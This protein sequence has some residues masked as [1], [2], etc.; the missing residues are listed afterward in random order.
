MS[1]EFNAR[2]LR[3]TV[4]QWAPGIRPTWTV[5]QIRAALRAH[6][7][8]D[9]SQSALL[10]DAMMQDDALPGELEKRVNAV[11]QS[12]CDLRPVSKHDADGKDVPVEASKQLTEQLFGEDWYH[13]FPEDELS[14]LLTWFRMLRVA[15]GTL[16]WTRGPNKW[17]PRLRVLHPQFLM[18]QP[19]DGVW[20]YQSREGRQVVTPGDGQWILLTDGQRGYARSSI[21]ALAVSWIIKQL[22]LRDWNR[23]NERHGLPI[24]K[25]FA[26]MVADEGDR[27][28]FFEDVKALN[29]ETTMLLPTHM[30]ADSA[31]AKYDLELLEAKDTAWETFPKLVDRQDRKFQVHFCGGNLGSEVSDKGSRAAADTHKGV[32]RDLATGDEKRFSTQLRDQGFKPIVAFNAGPNRVDDTPWPHWTTE[33]SEDTKGKAEGQKAFGDALTAFKTAGYKVTNIDELSEQFGVELEE[34]EPP[35]PPPGTPPPG[36][37]P[38]GGAGGK[39]PPPPPAGKAKLAR[40]DDTD[41]GFENGADYVDRLVES[42]TRRA[43]DALAVD[44][45]AILR[46]VQAAETPAMLRA[47]LAALYSGMDQ[48]ELGRVLERARLMAELAGK[49][50]VI[51]D[52]LDA[53]E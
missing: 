40:G 31:D 30:I 20:Y 15:V 24:V 48:T 7:E 12:D 39:Q 26:P 43:A 22:A 32:L 8:G 41:P 53:A 47:G 23:Y 16:D 10:A 49:Y 5:S 36:M 19:F 52:V 50:S 44:I 3:L 13:W 11:I 29:T 18:R 33:A 17:T 25:A 28:E 9:F 35:K 2:A 14:D 34:Q 27:E 6:T 46:V 45:A 38:A 51:E 21:I 4:T 1:A 37:P 42:G